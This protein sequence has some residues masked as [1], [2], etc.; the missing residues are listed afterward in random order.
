ML[1]KLLNAVS[2]RLFHTNKR[3]F[4]EEYYERQYAEW[5][6]RGFDPYKI[7][8]R[9]RKWGKERQNAPSRL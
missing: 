3:N 8:D 7:E 5:D 6:A 9:L 2:K 4:L 1:K